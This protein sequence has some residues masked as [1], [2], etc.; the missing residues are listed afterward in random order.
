M[1]FEDTP[2]ERA[3]RERVQAFLGKHAKLL[4]E[5][6]ARD[7]VL[8]AD[9]AETRRWQTQKAEAGFAGILLPKEYGGG[10]GTIA[11]QLIFDQ[12][13]ARYDVPSGIHF[14][15]GLGIC[16]PALRIF[17]SAEQKQR[18]L[19]PLIR[20]QEI[21][22]QLF[23]EPSNGSDLAA[24]RTKA[25]RVEGGWRVSGQKIWTSYAHLSQ[26]GLLLARTDPTVP[27]HAGLST[28]VLDMSAPGVTARPIR[29]I[30]GAASF[31]EVFFD[32][33]YVPDD[34]L[35]GP[36]NSG[37]KVALTMLMNER[38][39]VGRMFFPDVMPLI[40][41]ARTCEL[42]GA[43]A[44]TNPAV[45]EKLAYFYCDQMAIE[46]TMERVMTAVS[47]GREPGPEASII[48]IVDANREFEMGSLALDLNAADGGV[49]TE[50]GGKLIF[51]LLEAPGTRI[52]GGTEEILLNLIGERLL[53]LPGDVRI[54]R[55]VPFNQ[56]D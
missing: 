11:E 52:G 48:K 18:Y 41:L 17:G 9:L 23:S 4:V 43:P 47:K 44:I 31:N 29:Q 42:D 45:R 32:D 28:F 19:P 36:L 12:E 3:Y 30:T 53:G 34:A 27:K 10:G 49:D 26:F 38:L 7:S 21:W 46:H 2:E 40:Q 1:D 55:D 24:A 8:H 54:D 51:D 37:W 22:C 6:K 5:G 20:G 15:I 39:S 33:V 25:V 56:L 50:L 13:E 14:M 35:I 16:S